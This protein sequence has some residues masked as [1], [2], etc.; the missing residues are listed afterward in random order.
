MAVVAIVFGGVVIGFNSDRI[1]PSILTLA[2]GHG[3]HVTDVVGMA[4]IAFGIVLLW[5]SPRRTH[6]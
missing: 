4:L 5:R 6:H 2:R 3:I 1:D